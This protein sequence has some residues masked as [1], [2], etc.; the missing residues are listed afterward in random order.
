M[1]DSYPLT[2]DRQLGNKLEIIVNEHSKTL[3]AEKFVSVDFLESYPNFN[4]SIGG[5]ELVVYMKILKGLWRKPSGICHLKFS[6]NF[7][8]INSTFEIDW[9]V[10]KTVE[11]RR[12]FFRLC[13]LV[14]I[15]FERIK[16]FSFQ[17]TLFIFSNFS[18]CRIFLICHQ[19]N[20]TIRVGEI[21]LNNIIWYAFY[22][23]FGTFKDFENN[24]S[25]IFSNEPIYFFNQKPKL[26]KFWE[27]HLSHF[28]AN[29]PKF[30]KVRIGH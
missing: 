2:T 23:K 28:T 7:G 27:I 30:F 20:R 21:F 6:S 11:Y 8:K 10:S 13:I 12:Y 19:K 4:M 5:Y 17:T 1:C 18:K 24:S 15:P 29:L 26:L 22:Y 9:M 14:K 3:L 25:F 16:V